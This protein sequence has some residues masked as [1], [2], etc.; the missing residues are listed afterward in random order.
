[1][2]AKGD[3][4]VIDD[5]INLMGVNQYAQMVIKGAVVILTGRH[6]RIHGYVVH[7]DVAADEFFEEH[8]IEVL[9]EKEVVRVDAAAK[10]ITVASSAP[11]WSASARGWRR[12]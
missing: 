6:G 12:R 9:R 5:H 7:V 8:D 11:S 4:I 3:I 1:M 10:T 2:H